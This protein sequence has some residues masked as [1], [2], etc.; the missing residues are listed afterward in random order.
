[1]SAPDSQRQV[2]SAANAFMQIKH[3]LLK[4]ETWI[5]PIRWSV[6][7]ATE[8]RSIVTIFAIVFNS[9]VVTENLSV[10]AKNGYNFRMVIE[11]WVY[12]P[13][14]QEFEFA[15]MS[16]GQ[17]RSSWNQIWFNMTQT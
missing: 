7:N 11:L 9:T 15:W 4:N 3:V 17:L 8:A 10:A 6:T 5:A 12:T 14:T 16:A 2:P 13:E 1:M